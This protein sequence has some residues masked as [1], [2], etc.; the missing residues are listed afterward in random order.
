M[1]AESISPKMVEKKAVSH[2]VRYLSTIWEELQ[3]GFGARPLWLWPRLAPVPWYLLHCSGQDPDLQPL[4]SREN[5]WISS[6]GP[7]RKLAMGKSI[8]T[9]TGQTLSPWLAEY[10]PGKGIAGL[11]VSRVA[12]DQPYASRAESWGPSLHRETQAPSILDTQREPQ[13]W[14]CKLFFLYR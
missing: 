12:F 13:A 2:A 1:E 14:K 10:L 3:R 6:P 8:G 11:T 9:A 7:Q 4:C 5:H